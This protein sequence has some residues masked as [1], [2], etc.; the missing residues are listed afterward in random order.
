MHIAEAG[1]RKFSKLR[2]RLSCSQNRWA[3]SA[4]SPRG[5]SPK[6]MM[7][8]VGESMEGDLVLERL[9]WVEA[10]R[11]G[12]VRT[13]TALARRSLSYG[14]QR[15]V[16][17]TPDGGQVLYWPFGSPI[18]RTRVSHAASAKAWTVP[19]CVSIGWRAALYE[20]S[21]PSRCRTGV[22]HPALGALNGRILGMARVWPG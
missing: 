6:A 11:S 4:F 19:S 3:F 13:Q 10:A 17:N 20:W 15:G 1:A 2:Q 7:V 12:A 9:V 5:G 14:Y 18:S 8:A 22:R 21:G 16:G